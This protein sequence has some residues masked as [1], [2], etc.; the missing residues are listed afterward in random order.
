MKKERLF[1]VDF[2]RTFAVFL[3]LLT[4]YNAHY[5]HYY[6]LPERPELA[7][8]TLNPFNI[9]TGA[10]GVSLFFIISGAALMYVYKEK[11]DLKEFYTKRFLS[12]YPMFWIAYFTAFLYFFYKWKSVVHMDVPKGNFILTVLGMDGYLTGVLPSYYLLGEWFLG[13]IILM[14]MLFP[15]LRKVVLSNKWVVIIAVA[16]MYIPFALFEWFSNFKSSK[17]LFVRLPELLFG[18]LFVLNIKKVRPWMAFCSVAVLLGNSILKPGF[19]TSIQTTYVGISCFLLLVYCSKW[20]DRGIIRAAC[21]TVSKYSYAIFLTH[22]V[23]VDEL[24]LKFSMEE[25]TRSGRYLLF[26]LY[27]CLTGVAAWLLYHLHGRLV[28]WVRNA[29]NSG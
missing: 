2:V 26:I 5:L 15:L 6:I 28:S 22:H 21:H 1:Y 12:L 25:L 18:M 23:I 27:V 4:H 3:I 16:A 9:S 10:L 24:A 11:C 19:P 29:R 8:I 14:Y 20:F 13:C 7:I 17:I